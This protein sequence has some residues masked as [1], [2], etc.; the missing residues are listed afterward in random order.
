MFTGV[1]VGRG[2]RRREGQDLLPYSVEDN[3]RSGRQR[4]DLE[5]EIGVVYD[6]R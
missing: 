3:F 5:R 6:V 1:G 2:E 4:W